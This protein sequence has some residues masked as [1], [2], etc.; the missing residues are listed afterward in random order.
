MFG[1]QYSY[2]LLCIK[3]AASKFCMNLYILF[4][5]SIDDFNGNRSERSEISA[6]RNR[7]HEL[8]NLYACADGS[9]RA[10]KR[11]M[12][13]GARKG[14]VRWKE[15]ERKKKSSRRLHNGPKVQRKD[16]ECTGKHLCAR[17]QEQ[18]TCVSG[19]NND[20]LDILESEWRQKACSEQ[21]YECS[22]V[23]NS[24]YN[25]QFTHTHAREIRVLWIEKTRTQILGKGAPLQ[26]NGAAWQKKSHSATR[27]KARQDRSTLF[28]TSIFNNWL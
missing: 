2:T 26:W 10:S 16:G 14:W 5:I 11:T 28:L 6:H 12:G 20:R 21:S 22:A 13:L 19:T 17:E 1:V 18:N 23:F 24:M 4:G 25:T 8:I 3:H 27:A 15:I 9:A 7:M